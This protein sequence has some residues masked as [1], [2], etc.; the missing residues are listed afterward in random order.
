M[1]SARL[2]N[3]NAANLNTDFR[4]LMKRTHVHMWQDID[5]RSKK[6]AKGSTRKKSLAVLGNNYPG[7]KMLINYTLNVYLLRLL[8][9]LLILSNC[10]LIVSIVQDSD[11]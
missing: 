10:L 6:I 5:T 2:C 3:H 1:L 4:F 8:W 11:C 7:K 9:L